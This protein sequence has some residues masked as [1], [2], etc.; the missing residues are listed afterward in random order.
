MP[1]I[2]PLLRIAQNGGGAAPF[3]LSS[4]LENHG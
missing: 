1:Q 4:M 2:V 3:A